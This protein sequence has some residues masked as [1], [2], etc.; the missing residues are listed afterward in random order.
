MANQLQISDDENLIGLE[1]FIRLE[2]LRKRGIYVWAY[3]VTYPD[4]ITFGW[5]Y[6]LPDG[7]TS[8]FSEECSTYHEALSIGIQAASETILGADKK[9]EAN[10]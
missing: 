7:R 1:N 9:E 8:W 5:E 4:K 2:Y 6:E 3:P 10:G